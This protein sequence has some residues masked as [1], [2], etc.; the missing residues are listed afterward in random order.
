MHVREGR[1]GGRWRSSTS[2]SSL[3]IVIDIVLSVCSDLLMMIA[4]PNSRARKGRKE[5]G[6]GEGGA[7]RNLRGG[8]GECWLRE[9]GATQTAN[10]SLVVMKN[11]DSSNKTKLPNE[12]IHSRG[13]FHQDSCRSN[14]QDARGVC[15]AARIAVTD[16]NV[17]Y[18]DVINRA[19]L[20]GDCTPGEIFSKSCWI[21]PISDCISNFLID[22][23]SNGIAL[24]AKSIRK[25]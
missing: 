8:G 10:F 14:C 11:S 18:F 24:G 1:R 23:A 13:Y 6:G 20:C 19:C 12:L 9:N 21:K 4:A 7:W 3:P 16:A 25:W 5:G 22:V 17:S 2:L 15:Q